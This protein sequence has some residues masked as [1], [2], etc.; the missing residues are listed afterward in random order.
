MSM[1][2]DLDFN[3]AQ[4]VYLKT[5]SDQ[6]KR[7]VIGIVIR[8]RSIMYDLACGDRSSWHYDFEITSD[9]DVLITTNN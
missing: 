9:K 6:K 3:I 8:D 5:D 7:L 1:L 2:I 4:E